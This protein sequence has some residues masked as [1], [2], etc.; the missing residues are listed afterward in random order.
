MSIELAT[1]NSFFTDT[2]LSQPK[3]RLTYFSTFNS[4]FTDTWTELQVFK[5]HVN[6]FQFILH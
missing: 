2:Q 6:D 3:E 4:F 1:F 5:V